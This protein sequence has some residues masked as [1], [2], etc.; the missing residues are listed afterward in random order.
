[1]AVLD[2]DHRHGDRIS[3]SDL[4]KMKVAIYARVS[5]S[6]QDCAMQLAELREYC[7]RRAWDMSREYVDTGWSGKKSSR[8][9]LNHLMGDAKLHLFDAILV[10]KLDRFGRSVADLTQNIQCLESFGI[11]FLAVS[12]AIDTDHSNPTS[13]LMLHV[14]AAIAEFEA[15]IIRERVKAGVEHAKKVGTRSGKPNGR[16]RRIFRIDELVRMRQEGVS[17]PELARRLGIG[18]GTA[19]R[20]YAKT[21]SAGAPEYSDGTGAGVAV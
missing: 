6:D 1:M 11:R 12:Q 9:A 16:P 4:G 2:T 8:P 17:F 3:G 10:W 19:R 7:S 15:E 13:R 18:Q 5:T 21:L 14:L 20:A